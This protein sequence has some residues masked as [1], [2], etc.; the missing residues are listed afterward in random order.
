MLTLAA[1]LSTLF[2]EAPLLERF[3]RASAA[4]FRAVEIQFPYAATET[5]IARA[6]EQA[7]LRLALLNAPA[8][9]LAKG[10]FGLAIEG[11]RRFED[12]VELA[13]SYAAA[14]AC[15]RIHILVG[16][17]DL[18]GPDGE[19]AVANMRWAA[20]RLVARG[21]DLMLEALNPHDRPGYALGSIAQA[22]ALRERIQ[23]PKVKLQFDAYHVARNGEDIPATFAGVSAHVGHVQIADPADRGE[24]VGVEMMAFLATLDAAAYAG[25]VGA[26]YLPRGRTEDGLGW[27]LAYGVGPVHP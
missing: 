3:D 23:R 22:N 21:L 19:A 11:G 9:D 2:Q 1:N 7:D 25:V 20:D 24:P 27:A 16:Q 18:Q 15:P 17:G 10:D 5:E 12:S 14:T 13:L 8:G 26:E 6:L 4:G